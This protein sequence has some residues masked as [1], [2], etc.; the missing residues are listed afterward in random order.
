MWEGIVKVIEIFLNMVQLLIIMSVLI[1]LLSAD[2]YNPIVKFVRDCTEPIY[3][4]LRRFTNKIP[5]PLDWAPLI[6]IFIIIFIQQMLIRS[7]R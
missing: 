4:P 3:R 2:P 5:G 6:V 7:I 1:S